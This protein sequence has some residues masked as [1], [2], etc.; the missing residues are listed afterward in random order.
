MYIHSCIPCKGLKKI[1]EQMIHLANFRNQKVGTTFKGK[2]IVVRPG[3]SVDLIILKYNNFD[4]GTNI[5]D[6]SDICEYI[7]EVAN[8]DP[9]LSGKFKLIE[10]TLKLGRIMKFTNKSIWDDAAEKCTESTVYT[11]MMKYAN[12]LACHIEADMRAG[13]TLKRSF[14]LSTHIN[15][16]FN[17][18][19]ESPRELW[20]INL[21]SKVWEYGD[22]LQIVYFKMYPNQVKKSAQLRN[23]G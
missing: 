23:F 20:V 11:D 18:R 14:E 17:C 3:D 6:Y 15:A 12:Y 4:E 5:E 10:E 9:V 8:N 2:I 22:R 16:Y 19:I 7:R 21:L 1:V 13:Y